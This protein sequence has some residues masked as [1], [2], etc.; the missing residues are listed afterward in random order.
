MYLF[1][2]LHCSCQLLQWSFDWW[3]T[4]TIFNTYLLFSDPLCFSRSVNKEAIGFSNLPPSPF[5]QLPPFLTHT[6]QSPTYKSYL[7]ISI[8]SIL[9]PLCLPFSHTQQHNTSITALP[10]TLHI[11]SAPVLLLLPNMLSIFLRAS[12]EMSFIKLECAHTENPKHPEETKWG[13]TS[14]QPDTHT[15]TF[16]EEQ[17]YCFNPAALTTGHWKWEI[18]RQ[19]EWCYQNTLQGT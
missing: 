2:F 16:L 4:L 13:Q 3:R 19:W 15:H 18:Q 11:N 7:H 17:Y 5:I 9:H 6:V 14:A 8:H 1:I 12:Q 10:H